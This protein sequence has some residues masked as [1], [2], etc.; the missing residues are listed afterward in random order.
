M[1][2][3]F[4]PWDSFSPQQPEQPSQI[5]SVNA[6][7]SPKALHGLPTR[8]LT[9]PLPPCQGLSH[10]QN[11]TWLYWLE[12]LDCLSDPE[13]PQPSRALGP[14][15]SPLPGRLWPQIFTWL[16]LLS[17]GG[18]STI[19]FPEATPHHLTLFCHLA[20]GHQISIT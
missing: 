3:P 17:T 6:T 13:T 14:Q 11:P 20:F 12:S 16:L 9:T 1:G 5:K 8:S 4:T 2:L 15:C 7:P 19:T 18:R 10:S